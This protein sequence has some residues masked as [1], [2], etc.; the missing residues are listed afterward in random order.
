MDKKD[1]KLLGDMITVLEKK[2]IKDKIL[3]DE[4]LKRFVDA[5]GVLSLDFDKILDRII[6]LTI[7]YQRRD[8]EV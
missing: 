4:I 1:K 7:E 3:R 2:Q 8:K 6:D 5:Y